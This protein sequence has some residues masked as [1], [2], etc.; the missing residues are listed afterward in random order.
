MDIG[1]HE[2]QSA[3]L[4]SSFILLYVLL[5]FVALEY[6][7][8]HVKL[9]AF[10][11][12]ESILPELARASTEKAMFQQRLSMVSTVAGMFD[13]ETKHYQPHMLASFEST[14]KASI[15]YVHQWCWFP[16]GGSWFQFHRC[17]QNLWLVQLHWEAPESNQ[18]LSFNQIW[19]WAFAKLDFIEE[20][21]DFWQEMANVV[22]KQ[23]AISDWFLFEARGIRR[24]ELI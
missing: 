9:D 12:Q 5:W 19:G 18:Q 24:D 3:I 17:C 10:C 11:L 7:I 23:V 13:L 15:F 1:Q 22:L 16:C 21:L 20:A 8:A 4:V 6:N 2:K 14:G